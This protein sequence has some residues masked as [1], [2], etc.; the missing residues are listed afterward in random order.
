MVIF[1]DKLDSV[2]L[3]VSRSAAN[4]ASSFTTFSRVNICSAGADASTF[5]VFS[6]NIVDRFSIIIGCISFRA[7]LT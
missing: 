1:A 4:D 6:D 5:V 3:V 2:S 7:D